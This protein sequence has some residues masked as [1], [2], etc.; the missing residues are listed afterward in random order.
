[1]AQLALI[2][3]E[4]IPAVELTGQ[5]VFYPLWQRMFLFVNA[6]DFVRRHAQTIL[7]NARFSRFKRLL[8]RCL[9]EHEQMQIHIQ[10]NPLLQARYICAGR[11]QDILIEIAQI[12][13][14]PL[15][16]LNAIP[17]DWAAAHAARRMLEFGR[18]ETELV[19][20]AR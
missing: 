7:A 3:L 17:S 10:E 11:C 5:Q 13:A 4:Q 1:M 2:S 9:H 12:M 15:P 16:L 8:L 19:E 20:F 14:A 6:A 18:T